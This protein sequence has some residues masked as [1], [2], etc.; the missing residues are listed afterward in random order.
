MTLIR[1]DNLFDR[2]FVG[3]VAS[4]P[5]RGGSVTITGTKTVAK[6]G[7]PGGEFFCVRFGAVTVFS[8]VSQWSLAPVWTAVG[9]VTPSE[10]CERM[11]FGVEP[12]TW[13]LLVL[14]QCLSRVLVQRALCG[15]FRR[16]CGPLVSC[17]RASARGLA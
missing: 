2:R 12:V 8:G 17:E 6:V 15:V 16:F 13:F 10:C 5:Q 3:M 11:E 4:I 14:P 9:P 1:L 7:E